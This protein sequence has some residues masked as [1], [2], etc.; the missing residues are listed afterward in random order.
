[1][2]NLSSVI[3]VSKKSMSLAKCS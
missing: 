2:A 3:L 1:M